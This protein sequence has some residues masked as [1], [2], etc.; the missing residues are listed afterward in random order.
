[1]IEALDTSFLQDTFD[2]LKDLV[3]QIAPEPLVEAGWY[4]GLFCADLAS[5]ERMGN[6]FAMGQA[7][8]AMK[9]ALSG[10]QCANLKNM[11]DLDIVKY[12]KVY[13]HDGQFIQ[14]VGVAPEGQKG[15]I[16]YVFIRL[17]TLA[18]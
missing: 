11:Y 10:D 8:E 16:S 18:S 14:I 13:G 15:P 6:A 12:G 2:S 4:K 1:M 7:D 9:V 5:M 3:N 17:G